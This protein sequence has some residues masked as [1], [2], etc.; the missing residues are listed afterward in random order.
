MICILWDLWSVYVSLN[1]P[2]VC[3]HTNYS[4]VESTLWV[5]HW[6]CGSITIHCSSLRSL[7]I[8]SIIMFKK[9]AQ[10]NIQ[11]NETAG[12]PQKKVVKSQ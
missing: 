11:V 10:L 9:S 2:S 7:F 1:I 8:L 4:L 6:L 5:H 3:V 12:P